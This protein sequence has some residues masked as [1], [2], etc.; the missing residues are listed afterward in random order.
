MFVLL[1][2]ETEEWC[3][4]GLASDSHLQDMRTSLLPLENTCVF[5]NGTTYAEIPAWL[6]PTV[7]AC[8]AIA[9]IC[10]AA[11]IRLER[12]AQVIPR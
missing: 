10:T 5:A 9:A 7:F 6:N 2:G 8:A 11:A 12:R 3:A 1:I 4:K